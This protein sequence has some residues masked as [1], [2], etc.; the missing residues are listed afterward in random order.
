VSADRLR[1]AG[2]KVGAPVV[3]VKTGDDTLVRDLVRELIDLLVGDEDPA[4]CVESRDAAEMLT[5]DD[6]VDLGVVVDAAGTPPFLTS[7]RVVVARG[8]G[9][10]TKK[11]DVTPLLDYLAN[12]M[13]TTSLVLVWNKPTGDKLSQRRIGPIPKALVTALG[14]LGATVLDAS[15]GGKK[16]L[17]GWVRDHFATAGVRLDAGA[18]TM[19]VDWLGENTDRLPG[20]V[21]T[22]VGVYGSGASLGAAELAGYLTG[23]DGGAPPWDL[24]DAIDDGDVT[25]AVSV[26]HRMMR[27]GGRHPL[28]I[29]ASLQGH[30]GRL[31]ALDGANVAGKDDAARTLGCSPFQAQKAMNQCR[32][33]GHDRIIELVGLLAKADLDL[34]GATALHSVSDDNTGIV[35]EVLVAR[36]ASRSTGSGSRSTGRKTAATAGR[37]R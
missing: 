12:P 10:L 8:L 20:L 15:P 37:R 29:M 27:A 5:G 4:L 28:Q 16:D 32:R 34:R 35:M 33:L 7:R 18:I 13:P 21:T 19:I 26:L 1:E 3:M 31:L 9:I 17:T 6:E 22:L 2:V 25:L 14:S 11:D 36:M 23:G 30:V 24:T